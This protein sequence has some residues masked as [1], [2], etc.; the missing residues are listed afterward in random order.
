MTRRTVQAT[1]YDKASF[2]IDWDAHRV[3]CGDAHSRYYYCYYYYSTPRR[4]PRYCHDQRRCRTIE[5]RSP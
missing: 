3:I 5:G 2:N 4:L 1:G